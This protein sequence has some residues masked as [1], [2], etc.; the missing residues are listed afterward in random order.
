MFPSSLW[1][2]HLIIFFQWLFVIEKANKSFF[3]GDSFSLECLDVFVLALMLFNWLLICLVWV[4]EIYVSYVVL[5]AFLYPVDFHL[6]SVRVSDTSFVLICVSFL[7]LLWRT[8]TNT[9][10]ENTHRHTHTH[11]FSYR[12][13]GQTPRCWQGCVPS[14]NNRASPVSQ[15]CLHSLAWGPFLMS[16][17]PLTSTVTSP[18]LPTSPLPPS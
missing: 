13:R 2:Y 14:R 15:A 4:F 18:F 11:L 6:S 5:C 9:L 17:Q 7:L 1:K 16:M 8:T 3:S 12:T 10:A